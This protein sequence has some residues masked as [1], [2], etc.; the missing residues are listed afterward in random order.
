VILLIVSELVPEFRS[1]TLFAALE[2]AIACAANETLE[3]DKLTAAVL[4]VTAASEG[5]VEA[6]FEAEGDVGGDGEAESA[7]EDKTGAEADAG[8]GGAVGGEA[9]VG[10]GSDAAFGVETGAGATDTTTFALPIA[11]VWLCGLM[12]ALV[13]SAAPSISKLTRSLALFRGGAP[14]AV[15]AVICP[16]NSSVPPQEAAAPAR[17]GAGRRGI[18]ETLL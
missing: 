17:V 13:A 7:I 15:L 2:V 9:W 14:G 4:C 12:Q 5:G 3:G 18:R 8:A 6:G 1:V 10:P 11:A 16:T